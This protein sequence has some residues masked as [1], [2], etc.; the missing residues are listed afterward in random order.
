MEPNQFQPKTSV[1]DFF[2]NL[3]AIVALYTVVV[4]LLN[5]V[6]TVI[7]KAYPQINT[8][9][10][11]SSSISLP[12][13]ILIIFF[14]I[15]ILLMWLLEREYTAEPEKKHLGIRKWL[16]YITLFISGLTLAGDLVT[17][18]YYFLDGQ[19]LTA[20]FLLKIIFVL[21]ITLGVFLYYISDIREKLTS[22]SRKV[23]LAVS[24]VVILA[25]VIWGFVVLGSPLTQQLIKHDQ[26]KVSDLQNIKYEVENYYQTKGGLP[27]SLSDLSTINYSVTPV[28]AQSG[29][30]YEYIFGGQGANAYQ[31]CATFN[32]NSN[33]Q[34]GG[35]NPPLN[36]N[37]SQ[38]THPAGHYCFNQ[39]I[40]TSQY[41]TVPPVPTR[42]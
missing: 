34:K 31:L 11:G 19:E 42:N 21:I 36:Y 20:G 17:V 16:T 6:F 27:G 9:T 35:A 3:G 23:W 22:T 33:E 28:D 24:M 32:T 41:K 37:G 30:P 7:N 18:I 2:L 4:S 15:Y 5:L 12:V 40:S 13:S 25:S 10:N 39:T 14:P 26:Q 29:Q 8:Y 1:K 38:W